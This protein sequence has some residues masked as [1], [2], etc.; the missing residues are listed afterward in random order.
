MDSDKLLVFFRK[1]VEP[2]IALGVLVILIILSYQLYQGNNLREEISLSCGWETEDYRCFCEKSE[3]MAIKAKIDNNFT[4][5]L[6][7]V[8]YVQVDK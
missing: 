6:G 4:I 3:A 7:E 8:D 5:D 2:F 1:R